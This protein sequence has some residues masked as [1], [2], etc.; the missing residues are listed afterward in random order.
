MEIVKLYFVRLLAQILYKIEYQLITA[1][2]RCMQFVYKLYYI[3]NQYFYKSFFNK[4][5]LNIK[6]EGN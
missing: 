1:Q 3:F 2:S 5:N 4:F 6:Y